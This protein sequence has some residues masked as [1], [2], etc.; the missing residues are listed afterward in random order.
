MTRVLVY[1]NFILMLFPFLQIPI[2]PSYVAFFE[3]EVTVPVKE[4]LYSGEFEII[5]NFEVST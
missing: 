1:Y 3:V 5:T 4:G 2:K